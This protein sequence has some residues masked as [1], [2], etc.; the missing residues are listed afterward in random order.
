MTAISKRTLDLIARSD[1][2]V[3]EMVESHGFT[4]IPALL[5]S[6]AQIAVANGRAG[7]L[8]DSLTMIDPMIA[9]METQRKA[10][11]Q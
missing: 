4:I 1:S 2:I 8:R 9:S 5:G 3:A 11:A 6:I 10:T 7:F